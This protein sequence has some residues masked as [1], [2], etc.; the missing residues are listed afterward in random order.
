[1]N[2]KNLYLNGLDDITW[3]LKQLILFIARLQVIGCRKR[4]YWIVAFRAHVLSQNSELLCLIE[5]VPKTIKFKW[6]SQRLFFKDQSFH[7]Q[8]TISLLNQIQ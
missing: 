5:R 4:C 7:S 1:M 6:H 3:T 2:I 8:E